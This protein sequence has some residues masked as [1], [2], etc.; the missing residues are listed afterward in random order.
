MDKILFL[1]KAHPILENRLSQMGFACELD[2]NS[3]IKEVKKKLHGYF[4]IVMRS[5]ISLDC[6]FIDA[7]LQL[8]FIAR[9]GVGVEHIPVEY[10]ESKRIKVLT[11]PEGSR[12]TVAEH[13]LGM[14]LM[15]LNKLNVADRQVRLGRW[16][17]EPNRGVELMGK[18]VGILGYG[19]M[20]T[21]FAKRLSGFGVKTIVYDKFK[22]DY[23][24][25]YAEEVTFDKL[26][27]EA[28]ILSVHIPYL[29]ENHHFVNDRF[30]KKFKNEIYII[31]T[32]RGLVLN[33]ADLVT[34]LKSGKVKGAALDVFEYEDQSFD[35]FDL[36][37]LPD[38]FQY[39]QQA[40]SV[41]L[42]PHIAGWSF[43]SKR[44]HGEVL[45]AKIEALIKGKIKI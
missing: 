20:G 44:K 35:Q 7:G 9:E 38:D 41:V 32:A 34:N 11:S 27:E 14:L 22:T 23:G 2:L 30:I 16:E 13:A 19:N 37:E 43:E 42:A 36:H 3:D 12:D 39:L 15:L 18:T 25:Q 8:K 40:P 21:S 28:E 4:G 6:D 29:T 24:D 10:A 45:A 1:D 5:R 26:L 17:R 33:T 31:N